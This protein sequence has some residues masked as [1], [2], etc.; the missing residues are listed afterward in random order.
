M[1]TGT[2]VAE[3]LRR[4]AALVAG[5]RVTGALRSAKQQSCWHRIPNSPGAQ[6]RSTRGQFG[7]DRCQP[8]A[9]CRQSAGYLPARAGRPGAQ[10]RADATKVW[11]RAR[12]QVELN[13]LP[14]VP[15]TICRQTVSASWRLSIRAT[16][17][18]G[19]SC[20]SAGKLVRDRGGRELT[21]IALH[22]VAANDHGR[23]G[24]ASAAVGRMRQRGP[25]SDC[26]GGAQAF[27]GSL[28]LLPACRQYLAQRG[29]SPMES[30][31]ALR[32]QAWAEVR[33]ANLPCRRRWRSDRNNCTG[34]G[35]PRRAGAAG[36]RTSCLP[37]CWPGQFYGNLAAEELGR[38]IPRRRR[39]AAEFGRLQAPGQS[40]RAR[41]LAFSVSICVP[42][43]A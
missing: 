30:A 3:K 38:Q 14:G 25:G 35:G 29:K 7:A 20:P 39:P 40:R 21:A 6:R 31:S 41:T 27:A 23:R 19:V 32:Q 4:L 42:G 2:C 16:K 9:E 26:T 24:G 1:L 28:R 13:R 5:E 33:K 11:A 17:C 18:H 36:K 8:V 43:R 37:H 12:L 10:G 22:Y 15:S 34:W